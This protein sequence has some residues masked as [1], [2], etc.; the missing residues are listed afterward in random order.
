MGGGV[1]IDSLN[2]VSRCRPGS[3][4]AQNK[5]FSL[6]SPGTLRPVSLFESVRVGASPKLTSVWV[7]RAKRKPLTGYRFH[8]TG[9]AR[10][11]RD[12]IGT[13]PPCFSQAVRFRVAADEKLISATVQVAQSTYYYKHQPEGSLC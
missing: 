2:L 1:S 5:P 9:M 13:K 10:Q 11:C 3:N 12:V 4:G 8:Y 7:A 6:E